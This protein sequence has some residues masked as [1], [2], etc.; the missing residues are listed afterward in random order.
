MISILKF[1][2]IRNL[3]QRKIKSRK[4][5]S[6]YTVSKFADSYTGIAGQLSHVTHTYTA[7]T[8]GYNIVDW[9]GNVLCK[10]ELPYYLGSG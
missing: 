5:G 10:V 9:D 4:I 8:S 7:L 3:M 1:V 2:R 6:R